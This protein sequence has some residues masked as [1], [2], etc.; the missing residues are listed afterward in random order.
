MAFDAARGQVVLFGGE[1]DGGGN[2][3]LGDTW[4]FDG[5]NWMQV[6]S[7]GPEPRAF[8]AMVY[9]DSSRTI[10]LFGGNTFVGG[11]QGRVNDTW[12]WDGSQ[13]MERT[14]LNPPTE[15]DVHAMAFD[16]L[17]GVI[18]MYGGWGRLRPGDTGI[19]Q[20][21]D[22]WE[23]NGD[24]WSWISDDGRLGVWGH[25]MA[26]DT[27]TNRTI[28]FGGIQGCCPSANTWTWDG[29]AWERLDTCSPIGRDVA[30]MAFDST[31]RETVLFGGWNGGALGDTWKLSLR[32]CS[33]DWNGDSLL[34][35][36][37]FFDFLA[38]F[39]A[40]Y[41]DFNGRECTNSQDF[42]DFLTAFFAG[43]P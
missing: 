20:L 40:G 19:G 22:T 8:H 39:F 7:E 21:V 26:F 2:T 1:R 25:S 24:Q 17:R 31:S 43:C 34:N 4:E 32:S 35:S 11:F 13:W 18:V 15:R 9:D 10:V 30:A 12:E 28:L 38:D 23:W 14:P 3:R 42:F 41:A 16:S 33:A 36:Q 27:A 6:A 29:L 5:H 37:D